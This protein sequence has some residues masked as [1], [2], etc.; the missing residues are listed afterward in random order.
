MHLQHWLWKKFNKHKMKIIL[1]TERLFLREFTLQD[2]QLLFDLNNNPEVIKYVHE[3]KPVLTEMDSILENIILPQYRLYNH[4][5]W[6]VHLKNTKEFIGWC[7][8]KFVT[9]KNEID[10]GYRFLQP[11]WGYGYATES[12]TAT[13]NY[14]FNTL[15]LK[16]I[17]AKAHIENIAS[18][19]VLLK[20]GLFFYGTEMEETRTVFKYEIFQNI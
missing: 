1:E 16:R 19:N 3:P 14:G 6:A 5:R 7:G 10:I 20:C 8:L 9:E 15:H 13:I 17:T 18:Q 11:H 12:A 2:G 4:G